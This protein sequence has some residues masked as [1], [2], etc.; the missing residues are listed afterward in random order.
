MLLLAGC[1]GVGLIGCTF[2]EPDLNWSKPDRGR[3]SAIAQ[4]YKTLA[5]PDCET[6]LQ[7]DDAYRAVGWYDGGPTV[8][9][10]PGAQ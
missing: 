3:G 1:L 5:E 9:E 4:C 6:E 7:P 10:T 8:A 2:P